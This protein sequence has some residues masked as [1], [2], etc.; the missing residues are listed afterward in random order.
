MINANEFNYALKELLEIVDQAREELG[1]QFCSQDEEEDIDISSV[2]TFQ[3]AGVLCGNDGL[4]VRCSDGSE[5][6]IS[7]VRS[8]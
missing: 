2:E 5:F 7:V 3:N 6:Q 1:F 4:V 8:R